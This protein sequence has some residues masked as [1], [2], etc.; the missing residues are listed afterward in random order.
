MIEA[1]WRLAH[2]AARPN[3]DVLAILQRQAASAER[4]YQ[5]N[6][7]LLLH[8]RQVAAIFTPLPPNGSFANAAA[9]AS[10]PRSSRPTPQ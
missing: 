1:R 10:N 4:S 7:R 2:M 5:Q 9:P 3:S 8:G 6:Y